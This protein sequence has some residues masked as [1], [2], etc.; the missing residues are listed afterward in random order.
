MRAGWMSVLF[1][2]AGLSA[3]ALARAD[4]PPQSC[5]VPAYL[6][7]S[8]S[9]LPRVSAAIKAGGPLAI[10]VVGSRSSTIAGAEGEAYPA[11]LQAMLREKLP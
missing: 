3:S 7:T 2:M 6:L 1:V 11:R 8:D 10:L 4:D 5:D 9:P